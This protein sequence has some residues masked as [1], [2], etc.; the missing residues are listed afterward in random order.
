MR[1]LCLAALVLGA[2][3]HADVTGSGNGPATGRT[4]IEGE[5]P[6]SEGKKWS[7]VEALSDEF[8]GEKLDL[9]KWQTDPVADT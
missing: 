6:K 3:A 1:V 5:D 8:D 4:F 7:R 9:T 2:S